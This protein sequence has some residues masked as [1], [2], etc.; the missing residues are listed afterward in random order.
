M[1]YSKKV[2]DEDDGK[3]AAIEIS[4]WLPSI[5]DPEQALVKLD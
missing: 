5:W 1:G 3:N 2:K 4:T